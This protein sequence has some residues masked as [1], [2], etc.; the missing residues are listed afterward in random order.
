MTGPTEKGYEIARHM[1]D[2]MLV[3]AGGGGDDLAKSPHLARIANSVYRDMC[4]DPVC[5]QFGFVQDPQT[6]QRRPSRQ[7]GRSLLA[8]LVSYRINPDAKV[9]PEQFQE[10]FK[11]KFGKVRIYKIMNVDKESKDWA[12]DPSNRICDVEGG[13]FCRGQYPPAVLKY[14]NEGKTFAQLEDFNKK[15]YDEEY[16]KQYF[17]GLKKKDER[18]KADAKRR[19][20][21][22]KKEEL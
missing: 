1:A 13:W 22:K 8:N 21:S 11:S 16:R 3:W 6:R 14:V 9:D 18:R 2:Y 20:A 15:G 5:S 10:V 7:M 19:S 4:S 17:D 12:V